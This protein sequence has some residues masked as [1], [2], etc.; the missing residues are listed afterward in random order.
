MKV[1]YSK[2]P[3]S[4]VVT[5]VFY[6]PGYRYNLVK[7]SSVLCLDMLSAKCII[8]AFTCPKLLTTNLNTSYKFFIRTDFDDYIYI[9]K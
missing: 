5:F 8:L 1:C 4:R 9:T 7:V 6:I 2:P 3:A